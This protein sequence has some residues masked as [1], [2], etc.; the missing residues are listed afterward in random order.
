M[1]H[2][3][4]ARRQFL[5]AIVAIALASVVSE[6]HSQPSAD[7][8][9]I[10]TESNVATVPRGTRCTATVADF[11]DPV[12]N[13]RWVV[14]CGQMVVYGRDNSGFNT[15]VVDTTG[16]ISVNDSS[17]TD[18]DPAFVVSLGGSSASTMRIWTATEALSLGLVP[19][20]TTPEPARGAVST[21]RYQVVATS[22]EWVTREDLG[23][24]VDAHF[25]PLPGVPR[26][27]DVSMVR[28]NEN[29]AFRVAFASTMSTT[30]VHANAQAWIGAGVSV[31]S[32]SSLEYRVY[33]AWERTMSVAASPD[34]ILNAAS[35]D[36][37]G[38]Y[39][40]T[41][42]VYGYAFETIF[43]GTREQLRVD[44]SLRLPAGSVGGGVGT[45]QT[46]ANFWANLLGFVPQGDQPVLVRSEAEVASSFRRSGEPRPILVTYTEIPSR[47]VPTVDV[48]LRSIAY[49]CRRSW[50][51]DGSGPEIRVDFTPPNQSV[52]SA[53]T[54]TVQDSC[55]VR[56]ADGL[57]LVVGRSLRLTM[58]EPLRVNC[59]EIDFLQ[60]DSVGA[61]ALWD[62]PVGESVTRTIANGAA[63][64]EFNV[65]L[66][67]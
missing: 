50:D 55:S 22:P 33:R 17:W 57:G 28:Q 49:D 19:T 23:R 24:V 18:G 6:V 37:A 5:T 59:H 30:E 62:L 2:F 52:I 38:R 15:C 26:A 64:L 12:R 3:P 56:F 10:V 13:C 32:E 34:V 65:R 11:P 20:P 60:V 27:F 36:A 16:R 61:V 25:Q 14:M 31:E 29:Q 40:L 45:T 41:E 1:S 48:Y 44:A 46:G 58:D 21:R 47:G 43:R 54:P 35:I 67:E 63:T 53:P 66:A 42:I 4:A 39:V 9:L 51:A 7:V 8:E